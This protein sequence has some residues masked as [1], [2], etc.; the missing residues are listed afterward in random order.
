V[1]NYYSIERVNASGI[2]PRGTPV[3]F[4]ALALREA[5]RA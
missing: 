4:G 3:D 2:I 5:A 1:Q